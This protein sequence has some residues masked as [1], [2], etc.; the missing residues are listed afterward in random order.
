ME[1]KPP[2]QKDKVTFSFANYWKSNTPKIIHLMGNLSLALCGIGILMIGFQ[3]VT[4]VDGAAQTIHRIGSYLMLIGSSG[5]IIAKMFGFSEDPTIY[6]G[7]LYQD[8]INH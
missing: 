2:I 5:K 7:T 6:K 3:A 1:I 4:E 8:K